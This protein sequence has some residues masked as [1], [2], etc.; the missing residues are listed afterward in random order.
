MIFR[1]MIVA[2]AMLLISLS[3]VQAHEPGSD[4]V[5]FV[6]R[7]LFLSNSFDGSL[8]TTAFDNGP[9]PLNGGVATTV[10]TVRY[11]WFLNTGFNLNYDFG[12]TVGLF[13]GLGLKNIGFIE[14]IKPL[15][16]TVKRRVF[17]L[18]APLGVKIGNLKRKNYGFI[19]GGVD[20]PINYKEK[21]Y[22]RRG[23][24]DKINEWFS[25]RTASYMPYFFAGVSFDPGLY[26]KVQYYP[27]NFMNSN[28]TE[29]TTVNGVTTVTQPYSLYDIQVLM[30]SIGFDIRYTNRMKIKHT[31]SKETM[32]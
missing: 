5:V 20:V 29:T 25:D 23:N 30:F 13:T 9:F 10:S 8:F 6:P 2:T 7:K 32:M 22:V 28:F 18:G 17:S 26:I 21:G 24:K 14:K 16:S 4:E 11:T 15:D 27:N 1:K 31:E 19:G 3:V 12:K